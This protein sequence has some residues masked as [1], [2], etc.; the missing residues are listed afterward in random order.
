MGHDPPSR[1]DSAKHHVRRRLPHADLCRDIID[2]LTHLHMASTEPSYRPPGADERAGWLA[3]DSDSA[4]AFTEGEAEA[5]TGPVRRA[6]DVRMHTAVAR[7]S[8]T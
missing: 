6:A 1:L 5:G 4:P 7:S 3:V 2:G 8:L